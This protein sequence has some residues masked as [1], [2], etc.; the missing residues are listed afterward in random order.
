MRRVLKN[1]SIQE[2]FLIINK[3]QIAYS[4]YIRIC[5]LLYFSFY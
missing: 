3:K 4:R 5:N 1:P 2:G